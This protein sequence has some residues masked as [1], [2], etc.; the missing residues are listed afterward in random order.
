MT[1]VRQTW[2]LGVSKT[3]I[4]VPYFRRGSADSPRCGPAP[5]ERT[6]FFVH[7][8]IS[9][10][11][12]QG[13]DATLADAGHACNFSEFNLFREVLGEKENP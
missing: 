3:G 12:T 10:H 7:S 11:E 5:A 1:D 4:A 13:F 8:A 9:R 6:K 2:L